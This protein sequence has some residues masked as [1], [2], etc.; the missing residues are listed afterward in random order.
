MCNFKIKSQ[1]HAPQVPYNLTSPVLS[2]YVL[3]LNLFTDDP[4]YSDLFSLLT[5]R[6]LLLQSHLH[7]TTLF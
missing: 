4:C 1:L 2:A 5:Q 3:F 6:K 7:H